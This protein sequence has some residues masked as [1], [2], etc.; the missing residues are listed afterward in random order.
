MAVAA[1]F[2]SP[3]REKFHHCYQRLLA[4]TYKDEDS[5]KTDLN[6]LLDHLNSIEYGIAIV[7]EEVRISTKLA[8]LEDCMGGVFGSQQYT[9]IGPSV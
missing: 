4:F 2:S 5:V 6:I 1:N 7:N 3:E 9:N 8:Y